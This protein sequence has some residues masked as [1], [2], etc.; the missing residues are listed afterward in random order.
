M[1]VRTG[2]R[3]DSQGVAKLF[4]QSVYLRLRPAVEDLNDVDLAGDPLDRLF[5]EVAS[6]GVVGVLQIN[7]AA[8]LLDGVDRFFCG[9]P[10]GDRL[11]EEKADQLAF[12]R[13]DLLADYG[14]PARPE[15][16]LGTANPLVVGK[17][18]GG[19]PQ[20]GTAPGHLEG[21][22]P[23]IEGCR[24]VKVEVRPGPGGTCASDH[25]GYYGLREGSGRACTSEGWL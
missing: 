10:S 3:R 7:E 14:G 9:Q 23:A 2:T 19:E 16:R 11:L 12:S 18:D 24:A 20:L 13:Q 22:D 15:E 4:R 6:A 1:G 25:V 8:L 17:K 21:R 5:A